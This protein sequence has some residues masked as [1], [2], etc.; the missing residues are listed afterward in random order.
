M[1]ALQFANVLRQEQIAEIIGRSYAYQAFD[2]LRASSEIA[3]D[4]PN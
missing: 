1:K 4:P 2:T 3:L